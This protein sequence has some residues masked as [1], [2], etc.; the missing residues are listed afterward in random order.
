MPTPWGAVSESEYRHLGMQF[1]NWST[2]TPECSFRIGLPT[3]GCLVFQ[4]WS[5]NTQECS[6]RIGVPTPQ[7]AVS[8][9]EY[10]HL[11]M[12]FQNRSTN[13][14]ECSFRIGVRTCWDGYRA[15]VGT[16]MGAEIGARP[17]DGNTGVAVG[18]GMNTKVGII[19][20]TISAPFQLSI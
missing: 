19:R 1:Q 18:A 6:F 14:P 16:D 7:S 17:R 11:G 15:G 3:P 10:Q 9:L 12:Q 13:N 8:E 2:N 5:T 4:N 20:H